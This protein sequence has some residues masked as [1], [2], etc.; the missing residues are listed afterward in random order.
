[1]LRAEQAAL[2]QNGRAELLRIL[3]REFEY[4][5]NSYDAVGVQAALMA[6]FVVIVL[7]TLDTSRGHRKDSN[8]TPNNLP[9]IVVQ[10]YQSFAFLSLMAL[11]YTVMSVTTADRMTR[12]SGRR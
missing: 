12:Q 5:K 7:V 1:M 2:E 9:P 11:I 8:V 4:Y 3:D 6:S 10:A